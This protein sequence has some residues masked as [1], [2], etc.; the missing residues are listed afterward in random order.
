MKFPL[1][2][3]ASLLVCL[4][5]ALRAQS[6][7]V[8]GTGADYPDLPAAVAAVPPGA[9]LTVR[10]G[11]Y[12]G[13][14]TSKPLR[15]RL[16]FD[17]VTGSIEAAP[18]AAYAIVL[19]GMPPGAF[20]LV[21]DGA[22]VR[23]GT[24][25]AI[26]IT[27]TAG[28]VFLSGL[29]VDGGAAAA[30]DVQ[31]TGPVHVHASS[32]VGTPGL[33][34]QTATVVTSEGSIASPAGHAVAA[35]QAQLELSRTAC[36]GRGM[37][38]LHVF[39]SAVRLTGDGAT[40]LK[41][42]ATSAL[43]V[44]VIEAQASVLQWDP[45]RFLV[46]PANGAAPVVTFATTVLADD[47]PHLAVRGGPPGA[48]GSIRFASNTPQPGMVVVAPFVPPLFL[49]ATGIWVDVGQSYLVALV[50][51]ADP[52]GLSTTFAM[53]TAPALLGDVQCVQGVTFVAGLPVFT[54]PA[55]LVTL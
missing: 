3:I 5:P 26:R 49:G 14:T 6:F 46:V 37:S 18:G 35:V 21:G 7:T 42:T 55:P 47:P 1:T 17:A 22:L 24:L 23:G 13:F 16:D 53:P 15:I 48:T 36:S 34:A 43:P 20:V 41:V 50:G 31:N 10:P 40:V 51:I 32:L 25:G 8:G 28:S 27:N 11:K 45:A 30:L 38:A 44:P 33:Q 29:V 2:R 19:N 9:V 39:D 54:A 52:T 12:R 4:L